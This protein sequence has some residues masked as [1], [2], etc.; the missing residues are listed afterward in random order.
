[1]EGVTELDPRVGFLAAE[2]GGVAEQVVEHHP[3]QL[4]VGIGLQLGM[5][6]EFHLTLGVRLLQFARRLLRQLAQI[7]LAPFH[8]GTRGARQR[9]QVVDQQAH[10]LRGGAHALQIVLAAAIELRRMA[11][12][13]C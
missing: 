4:R 8:L 5:D 12:Q 11:A 7:D 10:A 1:M 2:L 13:Q 3:H 6:H 9:Q